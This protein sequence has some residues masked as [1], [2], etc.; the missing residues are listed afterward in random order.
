MNWYKRYLLKQG[1]KTKTRP[2][3]TDTTNR[4]QTSPTV[5]SPSPTSIPSR[6]QRELPAPQHYWDIADSG[7]PDIENEDCEV[8]VWL[9]GGGSTVQIEEVNSAEHTH[10]TQFPGMNRQN[11]FYGR[12]SSCGGRASL[13]I[14]PSASLRDTPPAVIDAVVRTFSRRG[15]KQIWEF[16]QNSS[17]KLVWSL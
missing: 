14:P 11:T 5:E 9:W 13:S 7:H 17:P 3:K 12:F 6:R 15:L 2:P 10:D 16:R 1:Q 8:F 4:S